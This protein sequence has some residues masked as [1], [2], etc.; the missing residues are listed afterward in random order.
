VGYYR[1][2]GGPTG[3]L[4]IDSGRVRHWGPAISQKQMARIMRDYKKTVGARLNK[5]GMKPVPEVEVAGVDESAEALPSQQEVADN[6]KARNK[7]GTPLETAYVEDDEELAGM[8]EDASAAASKPKARPNLEETDEPSVAGQA[9]EGVAQGYP[10]PKPRPKPIEVLMMAAANMKIEPAAA[11][12][13]DQTARNR[14]SPLEGSQIGTVLAAET[15]AEPET[16]ESGKTSLSEEL[17]NGSPEDI[18]VIEAM[19]ASATASDIWWQQPLIFD[20]EKAVRRDGQPQQFGD[21]ALSDL[22]PG[23]RPAQADPAPRSPRLAVAGMTQMSD[24]SGK[25]DMQVVNREGK[26]SLPSVELL[27]QRKA[28]NQN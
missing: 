16:D 8:S 22:L 5:K 9:P 26:G 27:F 25:G 20:P 21:S 12:P 3:F 24:S 2:G 28:D 15:L 17:R 19:A 10:A 14:A 1:S 4:H 23:V 11:P 18:P 13:P 6:T 7:K